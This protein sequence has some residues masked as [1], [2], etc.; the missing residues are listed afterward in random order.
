M[1]FPNLYYGSDQTIQNISRLQSLEYSFE[2]IMGCYDI[3]TLII[4]YVVALVEGS[5]GEHE[6]IP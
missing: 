6:E 4:L 5:M 1:N 2:L 3:D